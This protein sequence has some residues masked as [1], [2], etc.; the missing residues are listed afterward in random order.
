MVC[1]STFFGLAEIGINFISEI[2]PGL[3]GCP[4]D[5]WYLPPTGNAG[6][7]QKFLE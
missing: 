5:V 7:E 4:Q 2:L 3:R 6:K 1:Q